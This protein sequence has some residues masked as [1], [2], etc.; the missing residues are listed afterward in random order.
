MAFGLIGTGI[1]IAAAKKENKR[2]RKWM[3]RMSN[4]AYQRGMADMRLAGLNPILA[5]QK[6]GASTPQAGGG[7]MQSSTGSGSI[8]GIMQ[9]VQN[10]KNTKAQTKQLTAQE[11]LTHQLIDTEESKQA[12][13]RDQGSSARAVAANQ[14]AN[15][16]ISAQ[17]IER[18][19]KGG[20]R[21]KGKFGTAIGY[22]GDTTSAIGNI[23]KGTKRL[24]DR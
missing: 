3:E 16:A 9:T 12:L 17:E 8:A 21:H 24:G 10:I 15:A 6:G 5:Y 11:L 4:T 19:K 23:F 18:A 7:G 2:Q 20:E 14:A 13:M 22:L 1:Q